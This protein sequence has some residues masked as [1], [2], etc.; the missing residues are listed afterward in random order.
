MTDK[1]T[2]A[3]T[4]AQAEILGIVVLA[5]PEERQQR[6]QRFLHAEGSQALLHLVVQFIGLA[7]SVTANCR[8]VGEDIL[9]CDGGMHP[10]DAEKINMPTIFGA[11]A[12]VRLANSVVDKPLCSGCA[13]R[14]GTPANQ[15]EPTTSDVT[16]CLGNADAFL[17]HERLAA[18]GQPINQC[19]GHTQ[20]LKQ[21]PAEQR[22]A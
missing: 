5:T 9:V 20:A 10:H 19:A 7:N 16:W 3:L 17:C 15:C 21:L 13:Y 8:T 1:P 4:D 12:G 18:D 2:Y 14:L 22:A 6:L 11:I